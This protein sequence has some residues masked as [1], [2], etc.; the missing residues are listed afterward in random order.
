MAMIITMC[1]RAVRG[2]GKLRAA[3]RL[4][5]TLCLGT[6]ALAGSVLVTTHVLWSGPAQAQSAAPATAAAPVLIPAPPGNAQQDLQ[7][8][9]HAFDATTGQNLVWDPNKRSWVDAKSGQVLGFQGAF[10]GDGTIVPAPAPSVAK[11]GTKTQAKQDPKDPERAYNSITGQT[12]VWNRAQS[13]WIDTRSQKNVGFQGAFVSN[14]GAGGAPSGSGTNAPTS[15]DSGFSFGFGAGSGQELDKRGAGSGKE[16]EKVASGGRQEKGNSDDHG[17][18]DVPIVPF[19]PLQP[20][21]AQTNEPPPLQPSGG[22]T[23]ERPPAPPPPTQTAVAPPPPQQPP[24]AVTPPVAPGQAVCGPVVTDKVFATLAKMTRDFNAKPGAKA[25]ACHNLYG[26]TTYKTAWDIVGLNPET[27]PGAPESDDSDGPQAKWNPQT[28]TWQRTSDGGNFSA[29]LT[30]SSQYCAI[31]R[32]DDA[33][34]A[35]VQFMGTCQHAQVVNYVMWGRVNKLCSYPLSDARGAI[36]LRSAFADSEL[37]Q[38]QLDMTNIGYTANSADDVRQGFLTTPS[39]F[40]K[41][42]LKCPIKLPAQPPWSYVWEGFNV[43]N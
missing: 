40:K 21:I 15:P 14:T 35:T 42:A 4:A 34:A 28:G 13:A 19:M 39:Q 20:G 37:K 32:P 2:Y 3:R 6:I 24:T 8:P 22:H 18:G 5:A 17:G 12:L 23:V 38:R 30:G 26:P 9:D 1:G 36:H 29:W 27:S 43:N 10:A 33:C 11:N 41:C 25:M 31:P 7:Q 16:R